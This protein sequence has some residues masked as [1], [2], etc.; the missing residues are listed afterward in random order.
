MSTLRNEIEYRCFNDCRQE[1][2]PSHKMTLAIQNTSE[3]MIVEID[4]KPWIFAE[5]N[6]WEALKRMLVETDY[7][8]FDL[9][10]P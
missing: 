6:E 7:N 8:Q 4:G 10:K 2:C 9:S 5:P 1:G 3:I